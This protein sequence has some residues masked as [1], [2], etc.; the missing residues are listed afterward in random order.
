M[1]LYSICLSLGIAF[2][3]GVS[4]F[5]FGTLTRYRIPVLPFFLVGLIL[6]YH[7]Y[8]NPKSVDENDEEIDKRETQKL[9]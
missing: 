6:A 2:A 8:T 5:N 9:I 7:D 3:V 1:A 4:T